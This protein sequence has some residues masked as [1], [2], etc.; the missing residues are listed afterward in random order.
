[1]RV[2]SPRIDPPWS[3]E[4]GIDGQH[5]DSMPAFDQ[6]HA[7]RFD[8]G[9]LADAGHARYPEAQRTPGM[10]QDG[11]EQF[12]RPQAVVASR[13][14]DQG[15]GLGQRPPIAGEQ[16]LDQR[17]VL[18]IHIGLAQFGHRTHCSAARRAAPREA[19]A[20]GPKAAQLPNLCHPFPRER[21]WG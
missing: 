1:M 20:T 7:Q 13:R 8:E 9:R 2:L 12:L 17:E 19:K 5:G 16:A 6:V 11:V 21:G 10:R 18:P 15:D 4:D 14:F 3:V